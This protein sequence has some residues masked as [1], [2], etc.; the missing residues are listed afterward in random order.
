MK[1]T[2]SWTSSF[3]LL[4]NRTKTGTAP[5]S[6]TYFVWLELPDAIFVKAHAASN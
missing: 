6:I 5:A 2:C 1:F 3:V 4:N